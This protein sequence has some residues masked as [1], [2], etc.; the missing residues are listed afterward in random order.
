MPASATAALSVTEAVWPVASVTVTFTTS[1]E[2]DGVSSTHVWAPPR[3]LPFGVPA[4]VVPSPQLMETL[5]GAAPPDIDATWRLKLKPSD[6]LVKVDGVRV[7]GPGK[8]MVKI[9]PRPAFAP[10]SAVPSILPYCAIV[11]PPL[12]CW[13]REG[14]C[15]CSWTK[16]PLDVNSK[17]LPSWLYAPPGLVNAVS[18]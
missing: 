17:M 13:P 2:P 12:G 11:K 18:P 8:A 9:P 6:R 1:G 15:A 14:L 4:E 10:R 3:T 5:Y 16:V 7:R